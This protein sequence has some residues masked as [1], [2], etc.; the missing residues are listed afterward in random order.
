MC[1]FCLNRSSS[2]A[3]TSPTVHLSCVF[4]LIAVLFQIV[5]VT[6][7]QL[8]ARLV[9]YLF[10]PLFHRRLLVFALDV[11]RPVPALSMS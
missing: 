6:P 11:I 1:V 5:V 8:F 9:Q 4:F 3:V 2:K 7:I 10:Q